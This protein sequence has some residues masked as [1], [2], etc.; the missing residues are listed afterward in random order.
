MKNNS[1]LRVAAQRYT[2]HP[3]EASF[4]R[5]SKQRQPRAQS[6]T[7]ERRP[8]LAEAAS[9]PREK[10]FWRLPLAICRT[11]GRGLLAAEG[12]TNNATTREHRHLL[13]GFGQD[14][15]SQRARRGLDRHLEI[16]R[17]GPKVLWAPRQVLLAPR[18][19]AKR[20]GYHH[21]R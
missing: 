17:E 21:G 2:L 7:P 1:S 11:G 8:S 4:A 13:A 9:V 10:T 14:D 18:P 19:F 5:R 16:A 3:P 6:A 15:L 12:R 20:C